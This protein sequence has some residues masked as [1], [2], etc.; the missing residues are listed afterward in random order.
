GLKG[1][2]SSCC[3]PVGMTARSEAR[4]ASSALLGGGGDLGAEH[5]WGGARRVIILGN[6]GLGPRQ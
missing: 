5:A 2:P 6:Y 3:G 1:D 4:L